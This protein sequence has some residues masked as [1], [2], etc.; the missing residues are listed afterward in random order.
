MRTSVVSTL[1]GLCLGAT[2]AL[3]QSALQ[4][5]SPASGT[6]FSPGQTISVTVAASGGTFSQVMV[7]AWDPIGLSD[8]VT[9]PPF[10]FSLTIPPTTKPG[11]YL[12]TAVAIDSQGVPV[13]SQP[14][15]V[16]VEPLSPPVS[17]S[18]Q[19]SQ[20]SFRATGVSN[21]LRVLAMFQ[22]GSNS[23]VTASANLSYSSLDPT[24]AVVNSA[25]VVTATGL[26]STS[27]TVGYGR[28]ATFNVPVAVRASTMSLTPTNLLYGNVTI[29]S[30]SA[31]QTVTLH[32]ILG[33][34]VTITAVAMSGDFTE[35]DTCVSS[36]PIAAG[37]TC[38]INVQFTP[39]SPGPETGSLTVSNS[40]GITTSVPL[41]GLAV[42]PS[43]GTLVVS[44]SRSGNVQLGQSGVMYTI[45]VQ[46]VGLGA[47]SGAI[48]MSD[49][50]PGSLTATALSGSGWTCTL[51]PLQCTRADAL[52]ANAS[53][54]SI[55]LTANVSSNAPF[56]V[57]N[58]ASI[59]YTTGTVNAHASAT[60]TAAVLPQT[61]VTVMASVAGP[62]FS[63]D[64]TN[65]NSSQTFIWVPGSTH[66]V[67]VN[68]PQ[69]GTAGTQFVFTGWSDGA[70]ATHTITASS[71]N[72]TY[73]A[74][75]KLQYQLAAYATA[76]GSL[77]P[78]SGYYD[79][80]PVTVTATAN[81]GYVFAG[82][83]GG[84][85]GNASP[86][87]FSLSAPT[88]ITALFNPAPRPVLSLVKT[89]SSLFGRGGE[90]VY[91]LTVFN[92]AFASPT[93]GPVT[94]MEVLPAGLT[95][96][97]MAGSGWNCP[98]STC[99]RNDVLSPG[100]SYPSITVTV[101]VAPNAPNQVINQATVSG[102][103]AVARTVSDI[104]GIL[105]QSTIVFAALPDV[106][107]GVP[108]FGVSATASSGLA[109][110]LASSTPAVCTLNGSN[111]VTVINTGTCSITASQAGNAN[112]AAA[113]PVI[114]TFTVNPIGAPSTTTLV[115][116]VNPATLG[117]PVRL[118]ATV[119]PSAAVGGKV[120]FYDGVN[121]LGTGAPSSGQATLT[122]SL[123]PFGVRSLRAYYSGG[124]NYPASVSAA[125]T[126]IVNALPSDGF[127]AAVNYAT[128]TQPDSVAVGDL[129]GDGKAD[130]AVANY[131]PNVSV[132]LGNGDG[133][134][135]T[136]VQYAV[137]S[138]A[139]SVAVGDFNGDGRADLA[140][141]NGTNVSVLLGNGDGTFQTAVDYAVGGSTFS[142]V[143]GD[144]NGDGKADLAVANY[145][146]NVSVLLGNGDG[147]FRTGVNNVGGYPFSIVVGDFNGDGRAD[148]AVANF[149]GN[150]VSVLLGNGD[151]TFQTA[152]QYVVGTYPDSVAVGDFNG[153]GRAD[154][155]VTNEYGTNVS[156]LL[157]N[158][159]GTFQ[160]AVNYAV[161]GY[162]FS[163]VVGD[164]NG[165]G[166]AD[167][168]V[169]NYGNNV[170]V[171]LGNGDGTFQTA[172][173]YAVGTHPD[174]VAVGD[175]N[176]DGRADLAVA[177][178]N[179][180]SVSILLGTTFSKCDTNGDG[181]ITVSDV[182]TVINEALGVAP[183]VHDLNGDGQ[184]NVIDVQ[185]AINA[186]LGL[187][188][189]AR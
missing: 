158:G 53:Y 126:E 116:S 73:T 96:V 174:S 72:S 102:G 160:T 133:T 14:I 143:V 147:T 58:T 99:T 132:L 15:S 110:S 75:F 87:T 19:P 119:L 86:Q 45:S 97:S 44:V 129:N 101:S 141:A 118:T 136:A 131:G 78:A 46:N 84:L 108:P 98:G 149:Y 28:T 145:G 1:L 128:G 127:S 167:L 187:G 64:G 77:T 154:L 29:G 117:Q 61:Q 130:L 35:T 3:A 115:S 8:V 103:G 163:I 80:G 49:L 81:Q 104:T 34:P 140:V 182:Q 171:L 179:S 6:T 54:P 106:V 114:R 41:S 30:G 38:S 85:I 172:V 183:A 31:A 37:G 155:A 76:G 2:A 36:S 159:D 62:S 66:T 71:S 180:A 176:R 33:S 20:V 170:G 168:A 24:V 56:S 57:S 148:L 157:G 123:L 107:L 32:N 181:S 139:D 165:D 59:A 21:A 161:G 27:L 92:Y 162:P 5:T 68:S 22:D 18:V 164:F 70:A 63:V 26:G 47:N 89:H 153:D 52:A 10:Q 50:L 40:L 112:Y 48:T 65:Y 188:C 100:A 121:F 90:G 39:V 186:A 137:G 122:T 177:N 125:R 156:V 16:S 82:F 42:S 109:V 124:A 113:V 173:Q 138:S 169:A 166:K 4:I 17:I 189:S 144:F 95:L 135:Q 83:A 74:G 51:S 134:F 23:D 60:D 175:F 7:V 9:S 105:S 146:P 152:V 69:A 111:V 43:A 178:L 13:E 79:A 25:G 12:L 11:A 150:N 184:V 93:A 55:T 120:T 67:S 185:I 142:I 94:V 88:S 91:T 151:G